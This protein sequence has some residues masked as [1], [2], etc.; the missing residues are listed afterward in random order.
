MKSSSEQRLAISR[1]EKVEKNYELYFLLIFNREKE[2]QRGQIMKITEDYE[3]L[4]L[5]KETF[6]NQKR[7]FTAKIEHLNDE[8]AKKSKLLSTVGTDNMHLNE[9][10]N[11]LEK[12]TVKGQE[13]VHSQRLQ[14]EN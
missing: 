12:E 6:L 4:L 3:A 1:L 11:K 8:L 2:S 10:L 9:R 13:L 14:L 7:E 5:E